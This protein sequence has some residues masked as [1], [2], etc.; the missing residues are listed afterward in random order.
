MAA[1]TF[2]FRLTSEGGQQLVDDLRRIAPA[3]AEAQRALAA[4]TQASP[5]L[6]SVQDGVNAKLRGT[7]AALRDV[8][9]A[10]EGAAQRFQSFVQSSS[11][12]IGSLGGI[13]QAFVAG[14]AIGAGM[15]AAQ[16][17]AEKL[18]AALQAIP[19]AGDQA[20]QALARLGST[21]G[22]QGSAGAILERLQGLSRQ[23]GVPLA[24]TAESFQR[25]AI[26]A[27]DV[28]ATAS[29]VFRLTEG[30]QK[31]G[32]VSGAS[33][34][35]VKSATLQLGQAL[36]SGK[37]QGDELRSVLENMPQLAQAIARELG[38]TVG[39]LRQMGSDGKL[40]SDVVFPAM[41]RA[42]QGIDEQFAKMPVTMARA[43]Q[44]YKAASDQF[45][46]SIDK[47]I[48]LS[49]KLIASLE[50]S[51]KLVDAVRRGMGF[52]SQPER[53]GQITAELGQIDRTLSDFDG[54]QA[55][56][57]A[58]AI[59]PRGVAASIQRDM[60]SKRSALISEQQDLLRQQREVE[61]ADQEAA[62]AA[63]RASE[64]TRSAQEIS[65]LRTK[66]DT[67]WKAQ[68]E[69]DERV[70]QLDT[71]MSRGE[72]DAAEY[73]RLSK[74]ALDDRNKSLGETAK[75]TTAV[76]KETT[77]FVKLLRDQAKE[78]RSVE[79]ELDPA[80]AAWN[81]YYDA[82][83]KINGSVDAGFIG[84]GRG[85]QLRGMAWGR[86]NSTLNGTQEKAEDVDRAFA[87]WFSNA[88]SGFEDAIAKGEKFSNVIKGL[89][90]DIIRMITRTLITGPAMNA[91][92]QSGIG[93][94]VTNGAKDIFSSIFGPGGR[95]G[96]IQAEPSISANGYLPFASG[97]VMTPAG[98]VPLR[99]YAGGGIADS[100]Q[101]S[102]FG[103]GRLPEAYVP[104]PDRRRIPV[105]LEGAAGGTMV[106]QH[107]NVSVGGSNASP[108][109]LAAAVRMGADTAKAELT[110][111]MN[112]GGSTSKTFGRRR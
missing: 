23:T 13:G 82:I 89:E 14:G 12:M 57:A 32:I 47:S 28:G 10:A 80:T 1:R 3:S 17:A 2:A 55:N 67:K 20:R 8:S 64:K 95:I 84:S 5:Q 101:L 58:T 6:A 49:D 45:L 98:R 19:E 85:E 29:D 38:T 78:A 34:E 9:P 53:L 112:R 74:L 36:A 108:A 109:L 79:E 46:A 7:A 60:L 62:V 100:P 61:R 68:Q 94:L 52:A 30:I 110:A 111:D 73:A 91:L 59:N 106:T 37:L 15:A 25:M 103:E 102:M 43:Q 42:V 104:L 96:A 48:G 69:Y 50:R 39:Q 18:K 76:N 35:E 65:D 40:T 54:S 51:A 105:R 72:I 97:G 93:S 90:Q 22:D 71:A 41:L 86:L 83:A 24:D 44:Q 26:A 63:R 66:L 81:R 33:A 27:K 4:L 11:S 99:A 56:G 88:T 107:I 87:Q 77:D 75:T 21:L 70:K 16:M 92:Q 31:F